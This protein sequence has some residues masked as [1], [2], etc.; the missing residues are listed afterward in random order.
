MTNE[1]QRSQAASM[2]GKIGGMKNVQNHNQAYFK[3]L[4]KMGMA[5]R[6]A[7]HIKKVKGLSS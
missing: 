3:N 6:W 4:G 5:K 1:E 2:L 7:G